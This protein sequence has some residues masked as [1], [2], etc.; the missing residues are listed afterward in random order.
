MLN[1]QNTEVSKIKYSLWS[2]RIVFLVPALVCFT[3][4]AVLQI[5]TGL[6]AQEVQLLIGQD[7]VLLEKFTQYGFPYS[8]A[9]LDRLIVL[10]HNV[11][12]IQGEAS[13]SDAQLAQLAHKMATEHD[14]LM[15]LLSEYVN[16]YNLMIRSGIWIILISALCI[17]FRGLSKKYSFRSFG[18]LAESPVVVFTVL[19]VIERLYSLE[20]LPLSFES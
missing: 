6:V 3:A 11:S 14:A 18:E 13:L 7:Q 9:D 12:M 16:H 1:K 15:S 20:K 17:M 5:W 2:M 8:L 19:F 4:W 10:G